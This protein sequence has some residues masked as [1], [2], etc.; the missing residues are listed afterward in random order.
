ML[1]LHI[2]P[3]AVFSDNY[4]WILEREGVNR[5]VV[6]DPGDASPV[7][8]GLDERGLG[9][10]AVL[11][12][13]HHHDHVGGLGEIIRRYHPA[14]Y[15]SPADAVPGVDHP[16]E[17][18][19]TISLP[20][21]GLELDVLALPG[22]TAN[23]LGFIGP[24][25]ALVGDTLFAGGCGRVFEGTPEQ[26]H[27]ALGRLA[28]LVP[29]TKV[30]CAH[31]YTLANLRFALEVEPENRALADRLAATEVTRTA[32]QSTVPSTIGLELETNPFLR[33][34][35]PTVIAAAEQRAGRKLEPGAKI[36]AVIRGWKDG[37]SS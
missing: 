29:E 28:A 20:E 22:H 30:Y 17:D 2:W 24:G 14:V 8:A 13:H 37:W 26:M 6:V 11:L 33:C 5:V 19:D 34:S 32:E 3:V 10:G 16:V 9:V 15:G 36:F 35:E 21:I 25:L 27:G 1:M 12:T 7:I 31:E 18:G 23:H 4:V